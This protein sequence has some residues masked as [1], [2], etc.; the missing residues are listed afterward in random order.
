MALL[1][2]IFAHALQ[3]PSQPAL[4]WFDPTEPKQLQVWTY[5]QVWSAAS[6]AA[7]HLLEM[8]KIRLGSTHVGMMLAG[9]AALPV[10]E[11]ATLLAKLVIIPLGTEPLPRLSLMLEDAAPLLAIIAGTK[12]MDLAKQLIELLEGGTVLIKASE[13]CQHLDV[14]EELPSESCPSGDPGD[15]GDVSHIFFTSGSTGRPKGCICSFENLLSYCKAKNKIHEVERDSVV[16]VASPHTFD[17]SLGDFFSTWLAGACVALAPDVPLGRSLE[18]T[19]ASHV[20]TTPAHFATVEVDR[21]LMLR[22]VAL[23]GELMAQQILDDWAGR[24]RLLNTYGVTECT[25]YQA[26]A[27]FGPESSRREL[28]APLPGLSLFLAAKK[29]D[30]PTDCVED[31]SG[32]IGELWIAGQQVGLGYLRCPELTLERFQVLPEIGRCFRSG[33]LAVAKEATADTGRG[34]QLLG[35]RDGMVKLRGRRVELGEIE[36]VM[37]A[38]A[39]ELVVTV[40]AVLAEKLLV[41]YCVLRGDLSEAIQKITCSFLRR[42]CEERLPQHMVPARIL[43]IAELPLTSSGKVSRRQLGRSC[44]SFGWR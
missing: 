14:M 19:K 28:G 26:A 21:K 18:A 35:R 34:W 12:E 33:D 4:L 27:V 31:G 7:S 42:R 6:R 40:A 23:G 11:L 13:L 3:A 43:P 38:A 25:V 44:S 20:Q 9:G 1:E 22:T 8:A 24:V 5:Q 15:P 37:L 16:F 29:G 2:G 39:P 10:L 36:E 30:D 17:P 41:I 32:E